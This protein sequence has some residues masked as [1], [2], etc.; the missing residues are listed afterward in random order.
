[1]EN[2]NFLKKYDLHNAPEVEQAVKRAEQRTGEKVPQNPA[3]RIQNYLDRLKDIID[4]PELEGRPDFDRKERNISLLKNSLYKQFVINPEEIPETYFEN[5]RRIAREQGHGDIEVSKEMREQLTEV[6]I[7]DQKSTLDNWIDYL[8][9]RDATYPDWLKYYAFRSVLGMGEFD[10]E[11]KQFTKRSKGTVKPFP[12]LNREALAYVLDAVEKKYKKE[13]IIPE[14]SDEEERKKFEKLLQGENFAK[15][16]AWA[17]EKVTPASVDQLTI[18]NGQWVKYGRNSDHMLLVESLQGHGTGWC[19]AGESTAQT[20]LQGGDFYVYYSFDNQGKPIIPRVAIR[21]Q[22]NQ[23]AEVRGIAHEQNLDPYIGDVVK[24]KLAEFP[25]GKEYEKKSSDMKLLTEIEKKTKAGQELTK[26]DLIFLYE[27]D[28]SIE[29]FGYQRDPRI[30]ELR[31]QRNSKKDAPIVFECQPEEIA[32]KQEDINENTKT[33]VGEWNM[34]IFQKIRNYSNIKHLFELFPDKKIFMQSLETDSAINSPELAEESF[35]EKNIYL[36]DWGKDILYKTEFSKE[37]QK[38]ELVR[39]TVE[40]LGFPKGATTDEIYKK[41]EELGLE[42]CPAEVG[43]HLRLQYSGKD[44][45]RIAMKQI[46]DRAGNPLVFN[47]PWYGAQL[48]L[49][50]FNASPASWWDPAYNFVFRFRPL[51]A[52]GQVFSEA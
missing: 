36:S 52:G 9:S 34:E 17:I 1:M 26:N 11:K 2:P 31:S 25:D 49:H 46:T 42:L 28:S 30:E 32:W 13:Q 27:I 16:Y 14:S 39:F 22:E 44:W 21:M 40:Q 15:L 43:P 6:I 35:K 33:Y 23:I 10:K 38:Y 5:Q 8:S 20:Q 41:A 3:D 48:E 50:A 37:K 4:P 12:D 18:T 29:G 51:E 45:M 47:L 7:A 24:E 19:T